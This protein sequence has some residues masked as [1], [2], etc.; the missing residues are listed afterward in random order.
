MP[1]KKKPERPLPG[2]SSDTSRSNTGGDGR[3]AGAGGSRKT[4]SPD[5]D[6]TLPRN[7]EQSN[8]LSLS[9]RLKNH[10]HSSKDGTRALEHLK[11]TIADSE[12]RNKVSPESKLGRLGAILKGDSVSPIAARAP[13]RGN[14]LPGNREQSNA[15]S[16]S[17]RLKNHKHPS[18]DGTRALEHLKETIA[19]AGGR[20]E[21]LPESK[22]GR[23]RTIM[24]ADG[25]AKPSRQTPESKRTSDNRALETRP[26]PRDQ[27][28]KSGHAPD[29]TR[30]ATPD[31]SRNGSLLK[32]D[33]ADKPQQNDGIRKED[34]DLR[35][36]LTVPD[37]L[38]PPGKGRNDQKVDDHQRRVAGPRYEG[39]P[40]QRE[41]DERN[42]IAHPQDGVGFPH[43]SAKV[44]REGLRNFLQQTYTPDRLQAVR[45]GHASIFVEARASRDG[46]SD[47]NQKLT[48]D[49][50][51]NLRDALA[52]EFGIR[53]ESI[54]TNSVGEGDA[55][56]NGKPDYRDDPE[57]RVG[58]ISIELNK[59]GSND[60][61]NVPGNIE[62]AIKSADGALPA[63]RSDN[64]AGEQGKIVSD[65]LKKMVE[66]IIKQTVTAPALV[67]EIVIK[68][69]TKTGLKLT[70]DE[71]VWMATKLMQDL[72]GKELKQ[73]IVA[74]KIAGLE[75]ALADFAGVNRPNHGSL[76]KG[77]RSPIYR[78][79]KDSYRE[80]LEHL[81]EAEKKN[82]RDVVRSSPGQRI[83]FQQWM[84]S[85]MGKYTTRGAIQ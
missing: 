74:S 59:P 13:N 60:V 61:P 6:S 37:E 28:G 44:D 75:D 16:L 22:L 26:V 81:P 66:N 73:E 76:F 39:H 65:N 24:D 85:K 12:S 42:V 82:I 54:L 9:D 58:I 79:A 17:E 27:S 19:G 40:S 46:T 62:D 38:A 47:H 23:F 50:A 43:D 15:L 67:E 32:R 11:D 71:V 10:K 29:N 70:T 80:K 72:G 8:A 25:A 20:S 52:D 2:P 48:D 57:D 33:S 31:A 77:D 41:A 18:K 7:R 45:E 51:A 78:Q 4:G 14:A 21:I 84:S 35:S 34:K 30:I 63:I 68:E 3:A 55:I 36:D 69:V 53:P 5:R 83:R 1:E 49:R 64:N 56:K